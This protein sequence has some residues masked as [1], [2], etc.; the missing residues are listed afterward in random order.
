M[1]QDCLEQISSVT[2]EQCQIESP[3]P[4]QR[5]LEP[6]TLPLEESFQSDIDIPTADQTTREE[7][8]KE[9]KKS[10]EHC[11]Q[12]KTRQGNSN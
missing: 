12:G 4:F 1:L 9:N 8:G 3:E 2:G 7:V 5:F 10:K 11:N 6:R